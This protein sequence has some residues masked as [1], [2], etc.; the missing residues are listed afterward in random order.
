MGKSIQDLMNMSDEEMAGVTSFEDEVPET[1]VDDVVDE[2]RKPDDN[3]DDD[4]DDKQEDGGD[5]SAS[6]SPDGDDDDDEDTPDDKSDD[7]GEDDDKNDDPAKPAADD[8]KQPANPKPDAKADAKADEKGKDKQDDK[9]SKPEGDKKAEKVPAEK[10]VEPN[11]KELY[12]NIMKPFKANGKEIKLDS[13]EEAVKLMQ[14][15]ANYTRKMQAITPN[16]KILRMLET[17]GMLDEGKLNQ[18]IDMAK[19]NKDAFAKFA[20]DSGIDPLDIDTE[21]AV[22]YKPGNHRVS[23]AEVGLQS[24][25]EDVN[26]T[27]YGQDLIVDMNHNW[28]DASKKEIFKEPG[29]IRVLASQKE[30]GIYDQIAEVVNKQK[31]LGHPQISTL[32]F[33]QAYRMVGESLAQQGLLKPKGTPAPAKSDTPKAKQQQPELGR[34][35]APAKKS[36]TNDAKAKAASPSAKSTKKA[37]QTFNPLAL[38]DEEFLKEMNTRV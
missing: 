36:V 35:T 8:K 31:V 14:L 26:S 5:S 15:G 17:N 16:I 29:L 22:D 4:E 28:D 6:G 12:E 7:K 18:F 1:K 38:S 13:P 30:A 25:L 24:I 11:Y 37:A 23:D 9:S 32:P 20:K 3:T 33:I 21:K 10:A 19:G 27:D 2:D 34:G